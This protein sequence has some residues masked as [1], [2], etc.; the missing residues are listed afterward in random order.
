MNKKMMA[1][2]VLSV[3]VLLFSISCATSLSAAIP[4]TAAP[5]FTLSDMTGRQV[6]LA[7]YKGQ[8][9]VLLLFMSCN[10]GG[11]QDPVIQGYITR[12][13]NSS[14]LETLCVANGAAMSADVSQNSTGQEGGADTCPMMQNS[15]GQVGSTDNS[16]CP[17]MQYM[18]DQGVGSINTLPLMDADG[19]VS[20]AYRANPDKL[21]LVLVD[22]NGHICLRQEAP[23]PAETNTELAK[24]IETVTGQH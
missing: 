18:A 10:T 12:Y 8:K 22:L 24:Q 16:T 1:L 7:D 23:S 21:T 6:S 17:M 14:K 11:I 19:S 2:I 13:Q 4:S 15:A 3:L 9:A 20:Q 5:Q